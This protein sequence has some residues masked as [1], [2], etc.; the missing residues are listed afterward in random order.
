ME[1]DL[2]KKVPVVQLVFKLNQPVEDH[3]FDYFTDVNP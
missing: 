1:N 2:G 3:L